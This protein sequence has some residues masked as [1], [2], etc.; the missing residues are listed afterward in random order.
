MNLEKW[1]AL[2]DK[3]AALSLRERGILLTVAI[4]LVIFVWAQFFYLSFEKELKSTKSEMS[5]LQQLE[6]TQQN[7]LQSLMARLSNDPNAQLFA[8]QRRLK[9]KL[10]K[11]K[12][13]IEIRLSHLIEPELMADVM[14]EVL[15]D[16][17]G[18]RLVAA[19]NLIVEPLNF[20]EIDND[21]SKQYVDKGHVDEDQ[22]VLFSHRFEMV[23]NGSY[24]QTVSFLKRLEEME[25]FYWTMFK[26]EVGEYPNA[27]VTLQLSTLSLDE[28][29]IGV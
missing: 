11:L 27:K 13:Q 4:V 16:Y 9:G 29:W 6:I 21:N 2:K 24:F 26:Y 8:E 7:E 17:K 22:A 3:T 10:A 5:R 15:S 28:D 20:T 25:G 18:L 1:N 14:R 12:D 19:K 23:L